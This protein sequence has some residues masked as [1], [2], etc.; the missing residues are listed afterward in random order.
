MVIYFF[1][2]LFSQTLFIA[3]NHRLF[4]LF[5]FTSCLF[6]VKRLVSM[7]AIMLISLHFPAVWSD[8]FYSLFQ[9]SGFNQ[10]TENLVF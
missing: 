4:L 9:E 10:A 2:V 3:Q 7:V 1:W 5:P 8:I 6:V